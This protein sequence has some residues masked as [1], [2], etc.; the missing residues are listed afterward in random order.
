MTEATIPHADSFSAWADKSLWAAV[1]AVATL[2]GCK[3]FTGDTASVGLVEVSPLLLWGGGTQ[4]K[5]LT[6][7]IM[8]VLALRAGKA[9][10]APVEEGSDHA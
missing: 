8:A 7:I 3:V 5:D 10:V 4:V 1:L 9:V 6:R 2:I